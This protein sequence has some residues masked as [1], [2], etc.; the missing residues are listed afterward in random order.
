MSVVSILDTITEWARSNICDHIM[1]KQPPED[2]DSPVDGDY[3]YS[4]VHPAAFPMYVPT[5]DKLPPNIHSPFPSLCV[6]FEQGEDSAA[7]SDRSVDIQFCFSA[8]NPGAHGSD[9]LNPVQNSVFRVWS[10]SE[11]DAYFKRN[12]EGWRDVWNFVD[13]ALRAVENVTHIGGYTIDRAT[14]IKFGPLKEQ[15]SIPDFYPYWFAWMSFR[16]T[17]PLQRNIASIQNFL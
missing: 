6:R 12:S 2:I 4:R 11:A 1:L 15:E 13:I 16:V 10:G 7:N 17:C 9:M 3:Q 14:P 5:A 8:W